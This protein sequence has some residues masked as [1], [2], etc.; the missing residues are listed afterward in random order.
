MAGHSSVGAAGRFSARALAKKHSR[1]AQPSALSLQQNR[2]FLRLQPN[3]Y[4]S[5]IDTTGEAMTATAKLFKSGRSQAVR[6]P[7][8]F[9]FEGKEVRVSRHG[10]G[11]LLEPIPDDWQKAFA[12]IDAIGAPFMPEG[13]EQPPMPP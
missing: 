10:R 13:R 4:I 9:R 1:L 11:V 5:L 6:L 7:K 2:S 3:W 12:E 8:E